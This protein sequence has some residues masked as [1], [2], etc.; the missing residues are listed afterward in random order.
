M[1]DTTIGVS[2]QADDQVSPKVKNIRQELKLAQAEVVNM[3]EKFGATSKQAAEAAKKAALL[4]DTIQDA[5]QLVDAFNPDTKFRAFGASIQTVVGGFSA[6]TGVM[7]LLGVESENTQKLLLKV[8]SALAI[9]QGVAQLQEGIQSFRNLALVVKSAL[10]PVGLIVAGIVA[11]GAALIALFNTTKKQTGAQN[12]LNESTKEYT[13]AAISAH[14]QVVQVKNA[15]ELART[16]VISKEKALKIYNYTLGDSLG[17][18]NNL[19]TAEKNLTDKAEIYIKVTALKAQANS[20]FAISADKAAQA[21]LRQLEFEKSDTKR[22]RDVNFIIGGGAAA[23]ERKIAQLKKDAKEIEDLA[24]DL[25]KQVEV[26]GKAGG[27]N[28]T[29]EEKKENI[30]KQEGELRS[31]IKNERIKT[32]LEL[33]EDQARLDEQTQKRQ[34]ESTKLHIEKLSTLFKGFTGNIASL[35]I[36]RTRIEQQQAAIRLQIA[37]A[38]FDAKIQFARD[39]GGALGALAE[40]IGKQTAAGKV[41]AIAQATINTWLGVTEVLRTKSILPE[42]IATISR[43]ANVAAIIATGLTAI[44]N[45]VKTQ[46]PGGGGGGG[47]VGAPL[48]PQLATVT[49]TRLDQSQLNQIGNAT[50]RAFILESDIQNNRERITRL[51]RAARL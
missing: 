47:L 41:L 29:T 21:T 26:L 50:A 28:K 6:L 12:A 11:V 48:Q 38:E 17:K 13:K 51:N 1:A 18:T 7:G 24:V 40:L 46:V 37:E 42:P 39:L 5:S 25:L 8:Q 27:I 19:A 31:V 22:F 45:I 15:F 44:K 4:K 49:N 30:I 3:T 2:L 32:A 35:D 33:A 20:L 9:S 14:Q 10:G 34:E 23:E 36:E 16:G 43:I